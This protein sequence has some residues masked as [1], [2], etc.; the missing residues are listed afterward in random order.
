M[1]LRGR[2]LAEGSIRSAWIRCK[3]RYRFDVTCSVFRA[4]HSQVASC[5]CMLWCD[6]PGRRRLSLHGRRSQAMH[7]ACV[8]RQSGD[9]ASRSRPH[10]AA[11]CHVL[12]RGVKTVTYRS[13]LFVRFLA[14]SSLRKRPTSP[15]MHPPP[16]LLLGPSS[17]TIVDRPPNQP[18]HSTLEIIYKRC[19]SPEPQT[20]R[21][22]PGVFL[23]SEEGPWHC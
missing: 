11:G 16:P 21:S 14:H 13:E 5:A 8:F 6:V 18:E 15:C 9:C 20:C 23:A 2:R 19:S 3:Q 12:K 17:R 1:A 7:H 4:R 10:V 22:H